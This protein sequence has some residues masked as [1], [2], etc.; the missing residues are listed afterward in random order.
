MSGQPASRR[1]FLQLV[2]GSTAALAL[3]A[4]AESLGLQA[5][6]GPAALRG[7]AL[8]QALPSGREGRGVPV[9]ILSSARCGYCQKMNRERPGP[10]AG[11]ETNYIAYPL[12]NSESGAVAKAWRE[13]S[14]AGYRRFMAGGFRDAPP[15][16]MPQL[17]GRSPHADRPDRELSDAQLFEKYYSDIRLVKSLWARSDGTIESVTP[18]SYLF[19]RPQG[20]PA[21]IRL[22]GDGVPVLQAM[23][24]EYPAWFHNL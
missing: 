6:G 20:S 21:L 8:L 9:W 4:W 12:A 2:A 1:T 18:E 24:K 5:V 23:Q 17:N 14:I 19:V 16:P 13:R 15:L 3:P 10:V 7:R 22:P 11:I